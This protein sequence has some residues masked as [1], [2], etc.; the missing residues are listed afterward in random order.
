MNPNPEI[1]LHPAQSSN[2]EA[3]G[4]DPATQT[5]RVRFKG[6]TIYDYA[7]VGTDVIDEMNRAPSLGAYLASKIK[8]NFTAVKVDLTAEQKL[9]NALV[10]IAQEIIEAVDNQATETRVQTVIDAL[11]KARNLK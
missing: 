5:L 10:Q 6:G 9:E 2:V 4:Y 8:P 3:T 1:T 7:G 11:K